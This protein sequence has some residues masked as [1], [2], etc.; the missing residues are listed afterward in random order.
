MNIEHLLN[1]YSL[2]MLAFGV[3]SLTVLALLSLKL[4]KISEDGK[5]HLFLAIVLVTLLPTIVMSGST[6]YINSI[7]SSGGPVHWHA[8]IDI[9]ACGKEVNLKDPKG[10]SN[11]IGSATLHEH[12]DKR[13]HLEGVVL[14]PLDASLGNFFHVIGG[15]LSET[16][17]SLP[18]NDGILTLRNGEICEGA[19]A[20]GQ[21]QVFVYRTD[22]EGYYAQE[23]VADPDGYIISPYS[24]VPT[25]DCVIV[26]F[27]EAKDRTDKICKSY[28][29]AEKIGKLKGEKTYGN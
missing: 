2:Y 27:A 28:Q 19:A 4:K 12:N 29:V 21:V 7:S 6:V 16:S 3:I 23:K 15:E 13:I 1:T 18:T 24:S 17:V 9:Y 22:K 8:D 10:I 11:K 20:V 14:T 5:K 25:G 26:E